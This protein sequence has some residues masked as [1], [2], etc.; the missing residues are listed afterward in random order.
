M[1]T[2]IITHITHIL[3]YLVKIDLEVKY[4]LNNCYYLIYTIL[5]KIS[6]SLLR[7]IGVLHFLSWMFKHKW[8]HFLTDCWSMAEI[9]CQVS[10]SHSWLARLLSTGEKTRPNSDLCS[11]ILWQNLKMFPCLCW[12]RSHLTIVSI[13]V[14]V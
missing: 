4:S 9:Q 7:S 1:Y 14:T 11:S 2:N 10:S 8:M 6:T 13:L 3:I 5:I 12:K